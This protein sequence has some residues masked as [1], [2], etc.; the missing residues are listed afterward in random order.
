MIANLNLQIHIPEDQL[1]GNET[2]EGVMNEMV[3]II[4]RTGYSTDLTEAAIRMVIYVN[5][6][7]VTY[8]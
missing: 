3:Q 1:K 5:K 4:R 2:P 7:T 6:E 8:S